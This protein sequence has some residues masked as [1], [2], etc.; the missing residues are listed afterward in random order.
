MISDITTGLGFLGRGIGFI[1]RNPRLALLGMVPPLIVSALMI[2]LL[3]SFGIF[4]LD[5]LTAAATGW[6]PES[7]RIAAQVVMGILVMVIAVGLAVITFSSVTLLVGTPIYERISEAVEQSCGGVVTA[8]EEKLAASIVRSIGQSIAVIALSILLAIPVFLVGLVP[9]VGT[10]VGAVAGVVVGGTLLGVELIGSPYDRRGLRRLSDKFAAAKG[11]RM[12]A[13]GFGIPV[14]WL[15]SI[16]LVSVVLF[17]AATA[18]ATLLARELR[19][20]STVAASS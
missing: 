17:P 13:L 2:A 8:P 11:R 14:F 15:F 7:W 12:V 9:V 20:E 6:V 4:G 10:V 18:G 5:P 3:I 16:P 19:G 1:T